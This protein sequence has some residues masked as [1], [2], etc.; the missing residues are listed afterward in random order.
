LTEASI[1]E[2]LSGPDYFRCEKTHTRMKKE[3]CVRRQRGVKRRLGHDH[4]WRD[5]PVE[6]QGCEQGEKIRRQMADDGGQ[7][8]E[9]RGQRTEDRGQTT[10]EGE[11][12]KKGSPKVCIEPGCEETDIKARGRCRRHYN[13]WYS[14]EQRKAG[15]KSLEE[16]GIGWGKK[17]PG[18]APE[19]TLPSV[20]RLNFEEY[21]DVLEALEDLAKDE[22]R[23]LD[24]QVI[25][26]VRKALHLGNE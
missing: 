24:M 6:C 19:D 25:Y 26:L 20:V 18:A 3:E 15:G 11:M 23:P 7:K 5:V 9:D 21:P 17:L 8:T 22:L 12:K 2:V 1:E 16:R 14:K 4:T 10:E 13:A